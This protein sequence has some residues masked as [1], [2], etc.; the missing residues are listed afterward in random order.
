MRAMVDQ[1]RAQAGETSLHGW[2]ITKD[3]DAEKNREETNSVGTM[4]PSDVM[5]EIEAQLHRVLEGKKVQAGFHSV[6]F[7]MYVDNDGPGTTG[8]RMCRGRIVWI[9]DEWPDEEILYSPLGD[10]GRANWGCVR[11]TFVG[12]P[13]WEIG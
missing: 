8:A 7:D 4:G 1:L 5:P 6:L 2:V 10:Y 3:V 9:G 13:G 11:I 12:H